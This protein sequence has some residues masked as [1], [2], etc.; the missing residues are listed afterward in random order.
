MKASRKKQDRS[1]INAKRVVTQR[2]RQSVDGFEWHTARSLEI[3]SEGFKHE[4][5]VA[6]E[7]KVRHR[8][9]ANY[10]KGYM[11]EGYHWELKNSGVYYTPE[12]EKQ[13]AKIKGE[14]EAEPEMEDNYLNPKWTGPRPETPLGPGIL[15]VKHPPRNPRILNCVDHEG[16]PVVV[17]SVRQ[18]CNLFKK[19]MKIDIEKQLRPRWDVNYPDCRAVY[20]FVGR[21]PRA[22]GRW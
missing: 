16:R 18:A 11:R 8:E 21:Y 5:Q 12:G 3:M 1:E 4:R 9:L 17:K 15:E 22:Y 7:L 10:R 6:W 20:D 2:Q 14:L 13:A 19:G